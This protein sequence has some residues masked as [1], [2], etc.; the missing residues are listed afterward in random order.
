MSL[1]TQGELSDQTEVFEENRGLLFSVA[2]RMMGTVAD[3]EDVVQDA[4]LRWTG[5]DRRAVDDPRAYLVRV[6][7]NSRSTG[8][9]G[10]RTPGGLRRALA[11]RAASSRRPT[12]PTDV[13]L[14]ESVSLA[15][16]VVLETLS[17]LERAVFVLREAFGF[18]HA[19]IA[20][21]LGRAEAAS[22]RSPT[23]R[24]PTSPNAGRASPRTAPSSGG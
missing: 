9:A 14:A 2:Y 16:L 19:E 11:A 7:T 20:G 13:E 1:M 8:C 3:A 10:A 24:A 12:S 18:S 21:M 22:G 17:P 15:M 23:G 6:V 4:W 5:G